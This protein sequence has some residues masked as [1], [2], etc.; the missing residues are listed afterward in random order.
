MSDVPKADSI[1]KSSSADTL[2]VSAPV[3]VAQVKKSTLVSTMLKQRSISQNVTGVSAQTSDK[4]LLMQLPLDETLPTVLKRPASSQ[5]SD[6]CVGSPPKRQK[7]MSSTQAQAQART[8]AQIRAQTQ[9]A[10]LQKSQSNENKLIAKVSTAYVPQVIQHRI[11]QASQ[12]MTSKPLM[13]NVSSQ[14]TVSGMKSPTRTLAQIKSQTQ[15]AKAKVQ[16]QTRTLAQIKAETK[17][18]VVHNVQQYEAQVKLHAHLLAKAKGQAAHSPVK[19]L[20]TLCNPTARQRQPKSVEIEKTPDGVNLKRSLEICEQAKILSQKNT[21]FK[22]GV[23]ILQKPSQVSTK[24]TPDPN[25][26]KSYLPANIAQAHKTVSQIL[27]GK[28][29]AERKKQV[30]VAA[31]R[32]QQVG[33]Q[34]TQTP[35]SSLTSVQTGAATAPVINISPTSVSSVPNTIHVPSAPTS[36]VSFVVLPPPAVAQV[37]GIAPAVFN[38]PSTRYV[39]SSTAALAQE[40]LLQQL[41]R[42]AA[43]SIA[44][45]QTNMLCPQRAA[46]APPQQKTVQRVTTPVSTIVR[47]ASVG[48][49]AESLEDLNGKGKKTQRTLSSNDIILQVPSDKLNFLGKAGTAIIPGANGSKSST[50][51][52]ILTSSS[53]VAM[54]APGQYGGSAQTVS[55]DK[56]GKV[57]TNQSV[58][59]MEKLIIV[60]SGQTVKGSNSGPELKFE[61]QMQTKTN[62][63]CNLKGMKTCT[64][65][66]AFC[67]DDCIGPAKLCVTCLVATT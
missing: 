38:V 21:S 1:Q 41:I 35:P 26:F 55:V 64:K 43:G 24:N 47:S 4:G 52:V 33:V 15:A 7:D 8:L 13:V 23:S 44:V 32:A 49:N 28:T 22:Q 45:S 18:H 31:S 25:D 62:C 34:R 56:Q 2:T 66:G 67:H 51:H 37:S 46:S 48:T 63:D 59:K 65:C 17:A 61:N 60:S 57:V 6:M 5:A 11:V 9:V 50:H 42:S 39:I 53:N 14:V 10:R 3:R 40:N 27:Q 19:Q 12:D 30:L 36:N 54:Q 58:T 20:Q 29:L 16:G